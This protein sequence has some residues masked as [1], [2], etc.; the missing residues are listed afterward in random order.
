MAQTN[1]KSELATFGAG[2]FWCVEAVFERLEG[3]SD[4]TSGYMG[5]D[6]PN[7]TYKQICTGNTG[8]AEVVQ[9]TFDPETIGYEELLQWFWKSHDPTTLNRQGGDM[10]TQYRSA[11]FYHD[12]RQRDLAERSKAEADASGAF[13]SPI[14]TE[15]TPAST[16]WMAEDYHQ[17]FY[18]LNPSQPY[19]MA[20]IPPKLKKLGLD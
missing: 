10:G 2:C 20:V 16:Y 1:P 15:I 17:D 7:P 4:V 3:V 11:I 14:V 19:C 8:H 9:I 5:G 13:A 12:E 6:T 18:Q